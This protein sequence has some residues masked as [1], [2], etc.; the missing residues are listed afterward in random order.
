MED[1][2]L[3]VGQAHGTLKRSVLDDKIMIQHHNQYVLKPDKNKHKNN[4]TEILTTGSWKGR[5]AKLPEQAPSR[6]GQG[7][8]NMLQTGRKWTINKSR[9]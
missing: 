9:L 1:A 4:V 2:Q 6:S 8:P 5:G 7:A 3:I